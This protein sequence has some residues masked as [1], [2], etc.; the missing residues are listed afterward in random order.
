MARNWNKIGVVAAVVIGAGTL[1]SMWYQWANPRPTTATIMPDTNNKNRKSGANPSPG[2]PQAMHVDW[3]MPVLVSACMI[4]TGVLFVIG[5]RQPKS[6]EAK[7]PRANPSPALS[8]GPALRVDYIDG[9]GTE[10]RLRFSTRGKPVKNTP[11][12]GANLRSA[13][14]HLIRGRPVDASVPGGGC[15]A[16]V[17]VPDIRCEGPAC[18]RNQVSAKC[19]RVNGSARG[20]VHC[21]GVRDRKQKT[22]RTLFSAQES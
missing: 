9:R 7:E 15:E 22:G 16:P 2:D 4:V 3:W 19:N 8:T 6:R 12:R 1:C 21:F 10:A 13:L 20:N 17:G 18:E 5:N 11:S 14:W